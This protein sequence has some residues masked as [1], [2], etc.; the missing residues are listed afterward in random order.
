MMKLQ[1][2]VLLFGLMLLPALLLAP[3]CVAQDV[4]LPLTWKGEGKSAVLVQDE[5]MEIEF[6]A[7]I[8]VDTDGWVSGKFATDEGEAKIE[9]LYYEGSDENGR[10]L[11]LVAVTKEDYNAKLMIF[12]GRMLKGKFFY[13]EVFM[14]LYEK[15]GKVE[16]GLN[17]SDKVAQEIYSDYIPSGLKEAL[18]T[19]KPVGVFGIVGGFAKS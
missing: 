3:A 12:S 11:V 16:K 13:G 4:P 18:K 7:T 5:M 1:K 10:K 8:N 9:R 2:S 17:L 6:S 19:C 15:D 14:K